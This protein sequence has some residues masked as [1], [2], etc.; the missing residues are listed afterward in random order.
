MERDKK[1]P[2][3]EILPQLRHFGQSKGGRKIVNGW[4]ANEWDSFGEYIQEGFDTETL[5][6]SSFESA[7]KAF[8]FMSG[9]GEYSD[10]NSFFYDT[11]DRQELQ[12]EGY[13]QAMQCP[14]CLEDLR[15]QLEGDKIPDEEIVDPRVYPIDSEHKSK[16]FKPGEEKFVKKLFYSC[17]DHSEVYLMKEESWYE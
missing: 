14:E 13:F 12:D 10:K 1:P 6:H 3:S 2:I 11:Q 7:Q 5:A 15:A 9:I 16:S 4:T 8:A 17:R